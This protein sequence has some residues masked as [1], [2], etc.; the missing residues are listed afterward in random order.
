MDT[1]IR[2]LTIPLLSICE[3]VFKVE[4]VNICGDHHATLSILK[5]GRSPTMRHLSRTHRVSVAWLHEQYEREH[6][7]FS[8]VRSCDMVADIF[9]K[10]IP[11]P[12]AGLLLG[13]RL[14]CSVA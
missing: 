1:T 13:E 2:L 9:T 7:M 3:E 10:S 5:T 4:S 12:T 11:A 14:M 8:Y 6:F